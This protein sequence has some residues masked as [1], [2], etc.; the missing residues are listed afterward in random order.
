MNE[1]Q[2]F[3]TSGTPKDAWVS[4]SVHTKRHPTCI[5]THMMFG[6]NEKL[7]SLCLTV[8]TLKDKI[9]HW[10][11]SFQ[12]CDID[13]ELSRDFSSASQE[14]HNDISQTVFEVW[15][16]G[17]KGNRNWK[18]EWATAQAHDIENMGPATGTILQLVYW[19]KDLLPNNDLPWE[20]APASWSSRRKEMVICKVGPVDLVGCKGTNFQDSNKW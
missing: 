11:S 6:R 20:G 10:D 9:L 8:W 1:R 2:S 17:S 5:C 19:I 14:A 18:E 15:G 16:P 3:E 12:N 4:S 7:T 13:K